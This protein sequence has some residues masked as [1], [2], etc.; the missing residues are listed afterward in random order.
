M[1]DNSGPPTIEASDE[2][3]FAFAG[4]FWNI[5]MTKM[6]CGY[7]YVPVSLIYGSAGLEINHTCHFGSS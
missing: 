1:K 2:V 5:L 6:P 3:S 4:F 7:I